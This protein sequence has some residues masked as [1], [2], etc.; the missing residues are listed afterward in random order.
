MKR[1]IRILLAVFIFSTVLL[2]VPFIHENH[3]H[4]HEELFHV[5]HVHAWSPG[6]VYGDCPYCSGGSMPT[7][8]NNSVVVDGAA[9]AT[10][11]STGYVMYHCTTPGCSY[12][13]QVDIPMTGHSPS[14]LV[15]QEATCT[16]PGTQITTCSVCGTQISS[17]QIAALGHNYISTITKA[18]TC[19]E[20]G[21]Q[22]STCSRC[23]NSYNTT[24]KALGHNWIEEK[25]EPTC[26]EDGHHTKTCRRCNEEEKE[27]LKALGHDVKE[28]KTI[29]EPTCTEDGLKKATC[30][31]C[32]EEV[33]EKIP[34]LGHSYPEEWTTEKEAG[35][36]SEGIKSK[37][38]KTCH[39]KIEEKIPEK[40]KTPVYVAGAGSAIALGVLGFV[41]MKK[42]AARAGVKIAKEIIEEGTGL[43]KPSIQ[44]KSILV[45]SKNEKLID[46]LKSRSY[47]KVSTCD[48]ENVVESTTEEE[49]D[50][51]LCNVDSTE[52]LNEI[53]N[54]K[55]EDLKD[56]E[57]GLIIRQSVIDENKEVLDQLVKDGEI[58]NYISED[59]KEYNVLVKLVTPI[60]KPNLKSDE[61]LENIGM[62]ADVLGVPGI[63]TAI[64]VFINGRD[65]KATLENEELELTD[66][67]TII[68][69]LAYIL[70]FDTVGDVVDL[71]ND[72]SDIKS[73]INKE[74][75][76]YELK[77]GVSS[78]KNIVEVVSDV[79]SKD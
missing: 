25:V 17:S 74:A 1:I 30:E 40:D 15:T 14:T 45:C 5:H 53:L 62:L 68:A 55:K 42:N 67:A 49:P 24:L 33:E 59:K 47:L 10:C 9:D 7:I 3:D 11:T 22:V 39:E 69:D 56:Y 4:E 35:F 79:I 77:E 46:L 29:K 19:T 75:G 66:K 43:G 36:F 27:I 44:D 26:T 21:L 70:G 52:Q 48:Y 58:I 54:Y 8:I 23:N 38:C 78:A 71:V 72:M 60:L 64:D 63:S 13:G 57:T 34:K 32:H 37:S 61:T 50:A 6:D 2:Y 65:I 76:A 73:T 31:R 28:F 51:L 18:A 20:T 12:R 16:Q 41:F